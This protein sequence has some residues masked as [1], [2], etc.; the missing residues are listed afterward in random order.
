[1]TDASKN[2]DDEAEGFEEWWHRGFRHGH[3]RHYKLNSLTPSQLLDFAEQKSWAYDAVV[4]L[5]AHVVECLRVDDDECI[6]VLVEPDPDDPTPT[7]P[8][9]PDDLWCQIRK[10]TGL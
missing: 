5:L 10:V 1:M 3:T 2:H 4:D 8:A 9:L 6:H 7:G